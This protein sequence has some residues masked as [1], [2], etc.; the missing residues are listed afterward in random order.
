MIRRNSDY[1]AT[2]RYEM[3]AGKRFEVPEKITVLGIDTELNL[4]W[5]P[6]AKG[7]KARL[8]CKCNGKNDCGYIDCTEDT[9]RNE[10]KGHIAATYRQLFLYPEQSGAKTYEI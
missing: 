1:E 7:N 6:W 9:P 5:K 10:L 3:V 2:V 4:T 8:Y